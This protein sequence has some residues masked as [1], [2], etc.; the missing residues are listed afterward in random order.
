[1]AAFT[2]LYFGKADA[3]NEAA[4]HPAEFVDS[5][6]DHRHVIESLQSGNKFLLLG[7][8][9][10]GKSAAAW[11][12]DCIA[13]D[14]S[15]L[16]ETRDISELP[17]SEVAKI[18]TG[19]ADGV[20]RNVSAW[21]FLVLCGLLDLVIRDQS[22]TLYQDPDVATVVKALR[23]YGFLDP[24]P[25]RAVVT[26]SSQTIKIP[27]PTLGD[28]FS[29]EKSSSL[30]LYHLIP[31]LEKWCS[32]ST[33][34]GY[35]LFLDGLDS[36]YLNDPQYLPTLTALVNAVYQV[37]Q[38]LSIAGADAR[39]VLLVRNDIFSRLNL[40]DA[41]KMRIDFGVDLDWRILTGNLKNAPLF[42]MVN[43]KAGALIGEDIQV[44]ESFLPEF[45]SL[46]NSGDRMPIHQYLLNLTRHTPRDLLQL[47]E[48]I[49]E[50][51]LDLGTEEDGKVSQAVLREGSVRYTNK[52]FV[53]AIRN[54]LI[55]RGSDEF[56]AGKALDALRDM[57]KDQFV[58][59]DFAHARFGED[60]SRDQIEQ[61][62]EML[63][64]F[65]FAGALGNI[66][67]GS[68]ASYL[69]F[70][71]RR[72][73]SDVYIRGPLRLH[74]ALIY[75]WAIPRRRRRRGNGK[76][77][78]GQARTGTVNRPTSSSSKSNRSR[79]RRSTPRQSPNGEK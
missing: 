61:A 10:A 4:D 46:G 18:K 9:G 50:V 30:H 47:F 31:Y 73:D 14:S 49:R 23:S 2:D 19:E 79:S 45:A 53:D 3:K 77:G 36:I 63:R 11:Y 26:A 78:G 74:T 33:T 72:D 7:P 15:L 71:H 58:A 28:V 42:K 64:W 55:G 38:D 60:L 62:N 24:T 48:Q 41:G 13:P 27:I 43:R 20:G 34:H 39:I 29:S 40:P 35:R 56:E 67:G 76:K 75:A 16:V 6:V 57:G 59:E 1:M 5:F 21:R 17:L 37:N 32:I 12:L 44:V 52:Y 22:N 70:F 51:A 25:A 65:F 68:D 8:K 66:K 69:Q 54:E